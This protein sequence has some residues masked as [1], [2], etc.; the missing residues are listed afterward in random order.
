MLADITFTLTTEVIYAAA[1]FVIGSASSLIALY[2]LN[3]RAETRSADVEDGSN[4][5]DWFA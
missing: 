4:D 2:A 5:L 1:W 3:K